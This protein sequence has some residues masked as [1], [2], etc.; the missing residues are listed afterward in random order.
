M[1]Q[2]PKTFPSAAQETT[3]IHDDDTGRKK[4]LLCPPSR[5]FDL[6]SMRPDEETP[7]MP[8]PKARHL[9]AENKKKGV[10]FLLLL[11]IGRRK[12][13]SYK[14]MFLLSLFSGKH[15]TPT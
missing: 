10:C 6:R 14:G 2:E 3:T 1:K 13:R 7:K 4:S 8:A 15:D 5:F 11:G 9:E 12:R